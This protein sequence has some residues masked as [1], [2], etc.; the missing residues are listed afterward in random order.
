MALQIFPLSSKLH[1]EGRLE[2]TYLPFIEA[3]E[4]EMNEP[5]Q[6]C[7]S[8]DEKSDDL[9]VFF[10]K[11]GGV[12]EKFRAI[13]ERCRGPFLLLAGSM[14]NSLAASCEILCWLKAQGRRGEIIHGSPVHM[15]ERLRIHRSAYLAGLRMSRAR[16][17]VIGKPSPWLIASNVNYGKAREIFGVELIDIPIEKYLERIGRSG[18]ASADDRYGLQERVF[19]KSSLP[20]ALDAYL[21]LKSVVEEYGL[22]GLTLRCF[23][24]LE[25]VRTTGCI[26]LSLLNSE[27]KVAACE[28][29]LPALL[30]MTVMSF[31]TGRPVFM[32]NPCRIDID[33]NTVVLAHCTVPLSMVESY[34]LETHFESGIGAAVAADIASGPATVFR[35]SSDFRHYF[36]SDGEITESLRE[37]TL[38]RTQ[39]RLRMKEDVRYFLSGPL[40]NHHLVC[41]GAESALI[42]CLLENRGDAVP[43]RYQ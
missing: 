31:L 40:G 30:S 5:L 12:E 1:D 25:P 20:P 11:T 9:T 3:L 32:A 23:D 35:L 29:D 13:A 4:H 26:A 14:H 42:R 28:G 8:P 2:E 17:G 21:A 19:D 36:L 10:I 37:S 43:V 15:A 24:M 38:C 16:L 39:I 27:G 6:I 18:S 41:R 34:R 7:G 33:G 22:D